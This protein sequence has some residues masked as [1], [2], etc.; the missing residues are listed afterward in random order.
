MHSHRYFLRK[1]TLE[2]LKVLLFNGMAQHI[3]HHDRPT[4]TSEPLRSVAVPDSDHHWKEVD[5]TEPSSSPLHQTAATARGNSTTAGRPA[6]Q[7][8]VSVTQ[9]QK[10]LRSGVPTLQLVLT[11]TLQSQSQTLVA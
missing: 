11:L 3:Y 1:L 8:P 10:P 4:N 9:T 2:W 5:F 7:P 6:C